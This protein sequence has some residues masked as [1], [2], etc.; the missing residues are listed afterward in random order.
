MVVTDE[1]VAVN[2]VMVA[3]AVTVEHVYRDGVSVDI[4]GVTYYG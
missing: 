3:T 4:D 2:V 1:D